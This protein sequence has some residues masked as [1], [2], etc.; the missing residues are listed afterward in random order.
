MQL[1]LMYFLWNLN[2][3]ADR[4]SAF[5]CRSS[6]I[7]EWTTGDGQLKVYGDLNVPQLCV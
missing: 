6:G 1:P 5:S 2:H 3:T 4:R 7:S